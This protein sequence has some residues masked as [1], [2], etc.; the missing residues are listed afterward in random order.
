MACR[1]TFFGQITAFRS[2][3]IETGFP[4]S[5]SIKESNG[6]GKRRFF[7]GRNGSV[8]SKRAY[9]TPPAPEYLSFFFGKAANYHG[10]AGRSYKN[11]TVGLN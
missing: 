1:R 2:F 9:V 5:P 3:S 8:N 6:E 7:D 10:V 4:F 11:P